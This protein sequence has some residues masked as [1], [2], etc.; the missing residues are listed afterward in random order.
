M[1]YSRGYTVE[2]R[3]AWSRWTC[4]REGC[5][6]TSTTRGEQH[7]DLAATRAARQQQEAHH[8]ALVTDAIAVLTDDREVL[9]LLP[10]VV[11]DVDTHTCRGGV[12]V[13]PEAAADALTA[14]GT[15]SWPCSRSRPASTSM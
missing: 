8:E 14:W 2:G 12:C 3:A 7:D 4:E 15:S 9:R 5:G 1:T 13:T 10:S 6:Q 11:T